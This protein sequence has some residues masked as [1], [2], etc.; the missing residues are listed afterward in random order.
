MVVEEG[1]FNILLDSMEF[2]GLDEAHILGLFYFL[3]LF[4]LMNGNNFL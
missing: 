4:F 1:I 3:L 2:I